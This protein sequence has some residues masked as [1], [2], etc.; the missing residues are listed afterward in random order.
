MKR[1]LLCAVLVVGMA[2]PA[3]AATMF[4]S[5]N[6]LLALCQGNNT[7]EQNVC[8]GYLQG[9]AD[10]LGE[11]SVGGWRA[12][13]PLN[14]TVA[15]VEDIVVPWLK[16]NPSKRHYTASSLVALALEKAFPCKN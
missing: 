10:V 4:K 8:L 6:R 1:L 7:P 15:Q 5:G 2:G 16:A 11:D 14:V 12:C 13:I 9:V 3:G